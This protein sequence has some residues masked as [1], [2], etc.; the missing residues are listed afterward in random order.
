[1]TDA[2][3][4][5]SFEF[6][7]RE[8][9]AR[10]QC[11]H[12]VESVLAHWAPRWWAVID[13]PNAMHVRVAGSPVT[14]YV[15]RCILQK[16]DMNKFLDDRSY[17]F[18]SRDTAPSTLFVGLHYVRASGFFAT[19]SLSSSKVKIGKHVY[20]SGEELRRFRQM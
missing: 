2:V 20:Y 6:S 17:C 14:R 18:P 11:T 16:D 12:A 10:Y 19:K 4:R 8:C 9:A 7:S 15:S 3:A 5:Q 1:M 13:L